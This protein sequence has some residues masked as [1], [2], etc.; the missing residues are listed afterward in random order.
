M[1]D[2]LAAISLGQDGKIL[3]AELD[4]EVIGLVCLQIVPVFHLAEPLARITTLV[5]SS[6]FKRHGT[7]RRL[8]AEAEMLAW[9]HGCGHIEITSGDQRGDARCIL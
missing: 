3:V 2:R 9:E 8:I 6:K 5:I 7:G 4:T 1:K